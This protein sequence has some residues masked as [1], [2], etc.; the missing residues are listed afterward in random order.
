MSTVTADRLQT[1]VACIVS[2]ISARAHQSTK[3]YA[4][5]PMGHTDAP[6]SKAQAAAL[7]P[8]APTRSNASAA[9][10][11]RGSMSATMRTD[12]VQNLH[13]RLQRIVPTA[14]FASSPTAARKL[15]VWRWATVM[16]QRAR[17]ARA[18]HDELRLE[19][20]SHAPSNTGTDWTRGLRYI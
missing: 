15:T 3:A 7:A 16:T 8:I 11:W 1:I 14:M 20:D 4:R 17:C 9:R 13:A 12:A 6:T 19:T 2:Q 10:A 18:A 5:L